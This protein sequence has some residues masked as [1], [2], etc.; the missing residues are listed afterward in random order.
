MEIPNRSGS[1][2]LLSDKVPE[3]QSYLKMRSGRMVISMNKLHSRYWNFKRTV[4]SRISY[5]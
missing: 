2:Y 4:R 3:I 1:S 5:S